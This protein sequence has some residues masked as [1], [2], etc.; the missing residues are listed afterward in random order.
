MVEI[1]KATGGQ[2]VAQGNWYPYR[3]RQ[4]SS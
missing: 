3:D 1:M 2:L 4:V